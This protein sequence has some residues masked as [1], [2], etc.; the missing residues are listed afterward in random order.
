VLHSLE[1]DV[2]CEIVTT[3]FAGEDLDVTAFVMTHPI[4]C[5]LWRLAVEANVNINRFNN[6]DLWLNDFSEFEAELNRENMFALDFTVDVV[7]ARTIP[8]SPMSNDRVE[9]MT[10][11][12]IDLIA[13][14]GQTLDL[15]RSTSNLLAAKLSCLDHTT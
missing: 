5:D 4:S 8:R 14:T 13:P 15:I 1:T 7:W 3:R 11:L 10:R 6:G 9:P 12:R 2:D